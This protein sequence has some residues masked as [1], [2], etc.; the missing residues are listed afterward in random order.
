MSKQPNTTL[1]GAFVAGAV[2]LVVAALMIFGGGKF[3]T[4][5]SKFVLFFEG[6]VKGLNI[7]AP[8]DFKGVRVG[9]V[10]QI[11]LLYD[12]RDLSAKIPVFIE[13]EEKRMEAIVPDTGPDTLAAKTGKRELQLLIDNGLRA[14]LSS[15]SM[16]T[17]Q[18]YVDLDFR[19]EKPARLSG[20]PLGVPEIPT[21]PSTLETI[22]KSIETI[23]I[24]EL[25]KKVQST[26]DG[27]DRLVNSA[28]LHDSIAAL[29]D[30]LVEAKVLFKN[31]NTQIEQ[32]A[33]DT[34]KLANAI[35]KQIVP[36][37]TDFRETLK[38]TRHMVRNFSDSVG[39]LTA[40]V[41]ETL[42]TARATLKQ[43]EV[44]MDS[45][46]GVIGDKS[47]FHLVLTDTME[48]L[49]GAARSLRSVTDYLERHPESLLRGKKN[50]GK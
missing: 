7:G 23:S 5:K 43:A 3:M 34:R 33:H 49:S 44:A 35:E 9:S 30:T 2:V 39:P 10:T 37:A 13:I 1:I 40:S 50:E 12:P 16:V 8:V 11:K 6:S 42:K 4:S 18:L 45:V 21:V 20:V 47:G 48:E 24:D 46:D 27:I 15:Q 25:V 31:T 26:L 29:K 28:D 22:A 32:V 36:L 41:E 38:E 17:G 14:K 19:P